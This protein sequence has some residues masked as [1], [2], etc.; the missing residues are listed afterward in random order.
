MPAAALLALPG[1][2]TPSPAAAPSLTHLQPG[3]GPWKHQRA[4]AA[5]EAPGVLLV[6][7]AAAGGCAAGWLGLARP[8]R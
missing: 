3:A 8:L 5:A 4:A 2:R 6:E 1:R 7:V